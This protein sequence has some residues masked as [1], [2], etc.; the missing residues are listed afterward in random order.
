MK[1]W[2]ALLLAAAVAMAAVLATL[3]PHA[4]GP[5]VTCD[6]LYHVGLMGKPLVAA[7]REQGVAFWLPENIAKN[8]AWPADGPPVQAPLGHWI[9]GLTH[10]AMDPAPDNPGAISL[11]AARV[12]P[13]LAFALLVFLV[14]QWTW[15][16]AGPV[17][18]MVASCC[19]VL[20]PRLFAHAHFA[21]LDMLTTTSCVAALFAI[22]WAARS[23]GA[24]AQRGLS[25]RSRHTGKA[26]RS[27]GRP[28]AETGRSSF[29][30]LPRDRLR[31][32]CRFALAGMVWG[33]AMLIRLHGVLLLAPIALWLLWRSGFLGV[34]SRHFSSKNEPPTCPAAGPL[35]WFG[36]GV[37]TLFLGWPWLWLNPIEN[38]GRYLTSGAER[39][40]VHVYYFGQVWPDHHAPWHYPLLMFLWTVPVGF[41]MLGAVGGFAWLNTVRQ[42]GTSRHTH[43]AEAA[44]EPGN[45]RTDDLA[46]LA[47][48][49]VFFLA[50][51][52]WPGVPVYDGVRLFLPVFPLWAVFAGVGAQWLTERP[53]AQR[54]PQPV[55]FGAIGLWVAS[56]SIGVL[57]Y[58]P[59]HASYY[60][61]LAGGLPGA[62]RMGL[63]VNYWGDSVLEPLLAEAARRAPGQSVLY[64]P[65]LAP[66]Q[67]PAVHMSSPSLAASETSLV[68]WDASR[69]ERAAGCRYA[70]VY[71]RR[72][73]LAAVDWILKRGQVVAEH[74][75]QGVWLAR[76]VALPNEMPPRQTA[77]DE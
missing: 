40:V 6:E 32:W 48:A 65:H 56:Q 73:D 49:G 21:A 38:L 66:F 7:L 28:G 54:F 23:T 74:S 26:A 57:L 51:F 62:E 3:G 63:E 16:R 13:A 53:F 59:T 17:A 12:A 68:G 14:G 42:K 72:A 35:L 58:H 70:L 5:G 71:R 41:L 19:V 37:I 2:L 36:T 11:S 25:G 75:R 4:E 50:V 10:H 55:R 43:F 76:L 8:F 33:T 27:A 44:P 47:M 69:P 52:A 15:R 29:H 45:A 46:L 9:L 31:A 20:M 22:T 64:G 39:H 60:N 30:T 77:P 61:L 24:P 34:L 67:A 1:P 18:G